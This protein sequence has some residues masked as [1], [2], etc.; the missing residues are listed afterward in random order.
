MRIK[1]DDAIVNLGLWQAGTH[2][3]A[4]PPMGQITIP[5]FRARI[6]THLGLGAP[7]M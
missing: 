2:E 1:L 7:M 6:A 4:A 5:F 3:F